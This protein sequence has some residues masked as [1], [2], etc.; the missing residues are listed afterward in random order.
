MITSIFAS[1]LALMLV[2][3]SVNVIKGRRT[4]KIGVGDD[5]NM[6]LTLRIRAQANLAEYAPIFIILLGFSEY[7]GLYKWAVILFGI[8]FVIGRIL[9][10]Y[11]LLVAE[12]YD[13]N[14]LTTNPKWRILG[15]VII[16]NCLIFL[17]III[18]I[19]NILKLI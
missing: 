1:I 17:S 3:L 15:M 5:N 8:A 9:H 10:A 7:L 14:K 16:F 12:K 18:F 6:Q 13:G 19:Q 2:W 4:L 11:S